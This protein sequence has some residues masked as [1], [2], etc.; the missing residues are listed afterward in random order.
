[1]ETELQ[2][3]E[4]IGSD[5]SLSANCTPWTPGTV[6]AVDLSGLHLEGMPLTEILHAATQQCSEA[7]DT[8][9]AEMRAVR[10]SMRQRRKSL[11][12]RNLGCGAEHYDRLVLHALE[13]VAA[14][15]LH[16]ADYFLLS[17]DAVAIENGK[18]QKLSS[19][20]VRTGGDALHT[21]ELIVKGITSSPR[22]IELSAR[23]SATQ[24][25][26]EKR[27]KWRAARQ[28]LGKGKTT[29]SFRALLPG[30][31]QSDG[32]VDR[33]IKRLLTDPKSN[34]GKTAQEFLASAFVRFRSD[35]SDIAS[36]D[37]AVVLPRLVDEFVT[38]AKPV[39]G[40]PTVSDWTLISVVE[41][42][43]F[44]PVYR[45][46][47]R[48]VADPDEDE[49]VYGICRKWRDLTQE[50]L[51]I[52]PQFRSTDPWPYGT[53]IAK[54]RQ[55]S[56]CTTPC[57]KLHVLLATARAVMETVSAIAGLPCSPSLSGDDFVPIWIYVCM[58]ASL[59]SLATEVAFLSTYVQASLRG[60]E[61][62]YYFTT[63]ELAMAYIRHLTADQLNLDAGGP[64]VVHH[65]L[66]IASPEVSKYLR[67]AHTDKNLEVVSECC[68]L[69]GFHVF[70]VEEWLFQPQR[71]YCCVL[72]RA[73]KA[74]DA[75][76]VKVCIIRPNE[77]ASDVQRLFLYNQFALPGLYNAASEVVQ[78]T[79]DVEA[80]VLVVLE[81][82]G[83][84]AHNTG[85]LDMVFSSEA[86]VRQR[87]SRERGLDSVPVSGSP[88]TLLRLPSGDFD[89]EVPQ[90]R[91]TCSL[92]RMGCTHL[93]ADLDSRQLR[94]D[95]LSLL[96]EAYGVQLSRDSLTQQLKLDAPWMF[97]EPERT[98]TNNT[99][100]LTGLPFVVAEILCEIQRMLGNLGFL[101]TLASCTAYFEDLTATAVRRFQAAAMEPADPLF[102]S[103]MLT[104]RVIGALDF[105]T[106]Q[107][108]SELHRGYATQ[109]AAL[110][111]ATAP[112]PTVE[113]WART[114][115]AFQKS[116]G[117]LTDGRLGA[118]TRHS[119][120]HL[121]T[122]EAK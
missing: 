91:A 110:G 109:F 94:P 90:L 6:L 73:E 53:A 43:L 72:E 70:V 121:T 27:R 104:P 24:A 30:S 80:R 21:F 16:A 96:C 68:Y 18:H 37:I 14:A 85:Q 35:Q 87:Q 69:Q 67:W 60:G 93:F 99:L 101:P 117:L 83:F 71:F 76:P 63:L 17:L 28:E 59:R 23:V 81:R 98:E 74:T 119:L 105:S 9:D 13:A 89:A 26:L 77:N 112:R 88:L 31:P 7:H 2:V 79:E 57:A 15:K 103:E 111:F 34:A 19:S 29:A 49:H 78:V 56:L 66:H 48:R 116:C 62:Y 115:A 95:A 22:A 1:M 20:T 44:L 82:N 100:Q 40:D 41:Q 51:F 86:L 118:K 39:L 84:A 45:I 113:S 10:D 58:K 92:A 97:F 50:Q 106:V 38:E 25:E 102:R 122:A 42:Q 120:A 75:P 3:R 61:A 55:L 52:E 36:D 4:S 107:A 54:L 47:L 32:A 11:R 108:L 5:A 114:V 46:A 12:H 33:L 64:S 8:Y 65:A